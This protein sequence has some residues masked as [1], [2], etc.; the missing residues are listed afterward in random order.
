M[1]AHALATYSS[2]SSTIG[3][4]SHE[5]E[6]WAGVAMAT[7]VVAYGLSRRSFSGVALAA[8]AA[9]LA[10]RGVTG[11]W[12]GL[13][14]GMADTRVALAGDR[15]IHVRDAIRLE[16]PLEAVYGFWRRLENLPRFMTHLREVRD[17]GG[18][19]SHWI[20]DGPANVPVEWD[21]EIINEVPNKVIGWRSIAGS[22]IATAG[23]VHFSTARQGRSTQVSVNLQYAAPGGRATRLLAFVL[24]RDPAHMIRED[25]RRVKQ[26]LEA[27]EIPRAARGAE[28]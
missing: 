2:T 10:Y 23:S 25:L 24:G 18:G 7:A 11:E 4:T 14:N 12:P 9:P 21:A 3:G 17:L 16:V 28:A 27:G 19:R 26:L 1:Q 5:L 20:A 8:A 22:D 15:G 13:A 6:R